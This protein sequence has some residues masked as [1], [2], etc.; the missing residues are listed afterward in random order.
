[1][2]Y[3][4]E[5]NGKA[6][7]ENNL[8]EALR[9]GKTLLTD[10]PVALF[11]VRHKGSDYRLGDTV[12]LD[13]G[14][15]LELLFEWLSTPEFGPLNEIKLYMGTPRGEENIT[16]QLEFPDLL[17]DEIGYGNRF[18]QVFS[19]WSETPC[20]LRVESSSGVDQETGEKLYCCITNPIW[21]IAE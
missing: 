5:Q 8:Y 18:S 9:A 7:T 15:S 17:D 12:V 11:H 2:A 14:G 10:G 3:L 20:Y 16:A 6:L 21:I 19:N 13:H 4:P 1:M